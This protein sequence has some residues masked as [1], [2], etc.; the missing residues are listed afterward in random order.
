MPSIDVNNTLF[1]L[2]LFH[3]LIIST[4]HRNPSVKQIK[5]PTI[6]N[7]GNN[8][9]HVEMIVSGPVVRENMAEE[10][11]RLAFWKAL[12]KKYPQYDLLFECPRDKKWMGILG[13]KFEGIANSKICWHFTFFL[14]ILIF[15]C[16][17]SFLS[18]YFSR[19]QSEIKI[20]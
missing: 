11:K 12:S 1:C 4:F 5:W 7:E 19:F 8:V 18:I 14:F 2:C 6:P 9:A 3:L 10:Q 16:D 20:F 13:W 17:F 15:F